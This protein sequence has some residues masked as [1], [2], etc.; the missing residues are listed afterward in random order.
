[1]VQKF[2]RVNLPEVYHTYAA[3]PKYSGESPMVPRENEA[4]AVV[5]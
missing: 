1:M 4:E 3:G 2:V 5:C